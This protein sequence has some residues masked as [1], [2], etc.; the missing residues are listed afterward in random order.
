MFPSPE[1]TA[2][3][4]AIR[5][6]PAEDG[7][8]LIYADWLDERGDPRGE[9]IRLDCTLRSHTG[10][11]A[12]ADLQKR[13]DRLLGEFG[14]PLDG[15]IKKAVLRR[16]RRSPAGGEQRIIVL[17][18]G[19]RTTIEYRSLLTQSVWVDD[20]RVGR[21]AI[22]ADDRLMRFHF[23]LPEPTFSVWAD[24]VT[25][26]RALFTL[27][28]TGFALLVGGEVVYTE[29]MGAGWLREEIATARL[30]EPANLPGVVEEY[31]RML[32]SSAR[33]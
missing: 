9:I 7:P 2:F 6:R 23:P 14:D 19:R 4:Q 18:T 12:A 31:R 16:S 17:T 28:L 21:A 8:R 22:Y 11:K 5:D 10:G 30:Q 1:E 24:L 27:Y 20:L 25:Q 29:G 3:L 26:H 15:L 13:R 33:G 32:G